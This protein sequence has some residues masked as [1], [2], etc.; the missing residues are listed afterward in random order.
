MR[1]LLV[2]TCAVILAASP[3]GVALADDGDEGNDVEPYLELSGFYA[4]N[5]YNQNN[6]FLGIRSAAT[7]AS[8]TVDGLSDKDSY[9][10]QLFRLKMAFGMSPNVKAI[11]RGDL[12]QG[13]WAIDNTERTENG[14][15]S[16]NFNNK[17]TNFHMHWDWA[18]IDA[19]HPGYGLNGKLGRQKF[20]LGNLLVLDQNSDGVLASKTFDNRGAVTVGWAKMSEGADGL[21]DEDALQ[22]GS[23]AGD[24][25]LF[26]GQ[27]RAV[28]KDKITVYPFVAY[29]TDLGDADGATYVPNDL[30]YD[31][32]RFTPQISDASVFGVAVH[33][34]EGRFAYRGEFD[35]LTGNDNVDN[36]DSDLRERLDV[37]NGNLSGY[38]IYVDAKVDAL[39]PGNGTVGLKFGLGSGDDDPMSGD[40]NINKI[41]TNGFFYINEI[42]EDSVMP[43][44]EGI[45]PQGLGSPASRGYR[46][47]ENTTLVQLNYAVDVHP[48]L[49]AFVSG[50]W[51]KATQPIFAWAGRTDM[52]G[53]VTPASLEGAPSSDDLG[54]E[55]DGRLTW[56]M[57]PSLAA[58]LRGGAFFPGDGAGYLING[59]NQFLDTVWEVRGTV[60]FSFSGLKFG[61]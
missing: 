14:G 61:G 55:F 16:T 46:E 4:F 33:G 57:F 29:Y 3:C 20:A 34:R 60:R 19:T 24:A 12:A 32:P 52:D 39:G 11:V 43:D 13:I 56:K 58:V 36:K 22:G 27:Y 23:H 42:W 59:T 18:Y 26:L 28:I 1:W 47:F 50:T 30:Q 17:D 5:A 44:E 21:S 10:I 37:N 25:H 31:R 8:G 48:K 49:N 45:T 54:Y 7:D 6:F 35:Y 41:R 38:N 15:F 53:N 51:M 2:F 40:G 9:A